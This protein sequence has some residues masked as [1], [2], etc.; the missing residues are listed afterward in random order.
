MLVRHAGSAMVRLAREV[1]SAEI[2]LI[3]LSKNPVNLSDFIDINGNSII[4]NAPGRT[5][6]IQ[7]F[8]PRPS[9]AIAGNCGSIPTEE[10]C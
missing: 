6:I 1:D 5:A 7:G 9:T 2:P 3:Y 8:S 4:L 10:G